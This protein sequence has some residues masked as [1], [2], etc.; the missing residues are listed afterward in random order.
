MYASGMYRKS[1]ARMQEWMLGALGWTR[2]RLREGRSFERTLAGIRDS[3]WLSTAELAHFQLTA[4]RRLLARAKERVPY[5]GRVF[6]LHGFDPARLWDAAQLAVL[7]VLRKADV[8]RSYQD[9]TARGHVGLKVRGRTSG[10]MGS[11]LPLCQDLAAVT[12]EHAFIRRQLEW[13]GYRAGEKRAWFRGDMIVPVGTRR[14]P[15]WR[16]NAGENM[17]MLSSYHL[18]DDSC[19]AYLQAL[20]A[21]DPALIQ[22]Y[23]SSIAYLARWL[24][25]RGETARIPALRAIVTSSETVTD[26]QRKCVETA[27][28]ARVY[29]WYGLAERAAAIG[30]CEHGRYH[31]IS[32]YGFVELVPAGDGTLEIIG[33]GFGNMLM[34]LVRYA[35]RDCVEPVDPGERCECG[36]AFPLVRRIWGRLDDLI[37]TPDGRHVGACLHGWIFDGVHGIAEAQLVQRHAGAVEIRVAT[38]GKLDDAVRRRIITQARERLGDEIV[39]S[40]VESQ[41]I[42]RTRNGKLR[43]VVSQLMDVA[44]A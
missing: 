34:P 4:L 33:T 9:L 43:S 22:A 44:T 18:S 14:P 27:F 42:E 17:L 19:A 35:T 15:F 2:A 41:K 29:D 3:Q 25:N 36:R 32:D 13:A 5:Y 12:H 39:L 24:W 1:P 40:I 7:P 16:Y 26:E 37:V 30:T 28:G 31:I 23:P 38:T 21:F 20:R 10:T 6:K 11:S 8:L